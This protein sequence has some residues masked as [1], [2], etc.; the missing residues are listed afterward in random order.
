VEHCATRWESGKVM[1]VC[2]DKITCARMYQRIVPRWQAKAARLRDEAAMLEATPASGDM[3]EQ[4]K[5]REEIERLRRQAAWMDETIL[6]III[7]EGQNEVRD[8]QKWEFDIVP[9]RETMKCGF[10]TPDGR[11]VDVETAFKDPHHPFRVAIVCAMWLTGFDV[12]CL[13]TLYIDKPMRA[14]TLMQA[15]ARANRVY[16]GKACGI[17]VDYNGMLR[18]LREALSQYALGDDEN[19]GGEEEVVAPLEEMVRS[20][21]EELDAAEDHLRGLGFEPSRLPGARGFDRIEALRDAVNALYTSDA[22]KRRFEILTRQVFDRFRAL[23][24]EPVVYPYVERRDNLEPIY[25]KLEERRDTSEVTELLKELHRIVNEAIQAQHP[26][27]DQAVGLTVHL[28]RIDFGKLHEEF[29]SRVR[30]KQ[31]GLQDLRDLV[32]RKLQQ[33]LRHN[34]RL[35]DYYRKYQ[36][37]IADYNREKDR[38]T[39]EQTFAQLLDLYASLDAEEQRI[40]QEGLSADEL[41]L[42]DMLAKEN[43]SK[44]E[45]EKL[46][47]ASRSLLASLLELLRPMERWTEKEQT[48]AE[49]RVFILD[50]LFEALP[51][52][53]YS[54]EE[55]QRVA[56]EVYNYVWQRSAGGYPLEPVTAA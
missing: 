20:L 15:I 3:E 27:D 47:Q 48:Q 31:T 53:P 52:P 45:R 30:R 36:E 29:A 5:R 56:D 42:F 18:S 37:I 7:S 11:R 23:L 54:P 32:E 44:S 34:P 25:K 35:M 24:T 38:A 51:N 49:V 33:I 50:R 6:E 26:G 12:E 9:H 55:T 40:V 17:I 28:S 43:L 22:E 14:H 10:E 46:K 13:S 16:P 21:V 2:I 1:L 4:Q 41:A 19:G 39:V 8:F